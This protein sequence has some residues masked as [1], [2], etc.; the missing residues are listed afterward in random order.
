[1]NK[2]DLIN[3]VAASTNFK[4]T[5]IKATLEAVLNAISNCV[6]KGEKVSILGFGTF[7]VIDKAARIGVSP[8]SHT[9][10]EIPAKK[11]IKFKAS[12]DFEAKIK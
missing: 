3:S 8:N 4:K 2:V 7:K 6:T 5:D 10:I 9:K 1:M 12:P 11:S